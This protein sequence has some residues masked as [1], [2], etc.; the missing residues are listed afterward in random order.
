MSFDYFYLKPTR[1]YA[2]ICIYVRFNSDLKNVKISRELSVQL[3]LSTVSTIGRGH[4]I[5]VH[6][7][8]NAYENANKTYG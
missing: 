1:M 4:K 7:F 3:E 5:Y 8:L 6:L 2:L